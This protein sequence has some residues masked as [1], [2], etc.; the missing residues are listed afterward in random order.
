MASRGRAVLV[1]VRKA[2]NFD[3]QH[4]EGAVNVP[5]FAP[6]AVRISARLM[7]NFV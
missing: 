2:S 5:L 4:A 6:V 3:A 1:D 7:S